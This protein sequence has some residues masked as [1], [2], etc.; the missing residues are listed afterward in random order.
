MISAPKV[1]TFV[2]VEVLVEVVVI[3]VEVIVDVEVV[4]VLVVV[5]LVVVVSAW[6]RDLH[7]FYRGLQHW[8]LEEWESMGV[9]E[10]A[11]SARK[12]MASALDPRHLVQ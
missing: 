2:V 7:D 6:S 1:P 5:V 8:N 4:E 3:V 11:D 12:E 9:F 10:F